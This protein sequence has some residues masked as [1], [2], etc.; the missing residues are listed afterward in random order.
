MMTRISFSGKPVTST[1]MADEC[2][3]PQ[4]LCTQLLDL[5]VQLFR[6][7]VVIWYLFKR[8]YK[9]GIGVMIAF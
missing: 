9:E 1:F 5:Q 3:E 7:I 2:V 8:T 4:H 6:F